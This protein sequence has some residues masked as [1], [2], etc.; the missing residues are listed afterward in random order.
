MPPLVA[1][2]ENWLILQLGT[3]KHAL[4]V[5]ASGS[6]AQLAYAHRVAGTVY[7]KFQ[8]VDQGETV[9]ADG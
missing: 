2:P 1:A 4:K 6:R 5:A 7:L 9:L 8:K 3:V